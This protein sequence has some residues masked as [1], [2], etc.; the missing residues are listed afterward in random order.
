MR[1]P[2]RISEAEIDRFTGI[3]TPNNLS[4]FRRNLIHSEGK[5]QDGL[6]DI[7]ECKRQ[8]AQLLLA[9]KSAG[10]EALEEYGEQDYEVPFYPFYQ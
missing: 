10:P 4:T 5:K 8:A 1:T 6:A 9:A 3:T 7:I 2:R